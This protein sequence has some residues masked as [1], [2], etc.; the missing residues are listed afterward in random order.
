MVEVLDAAKVVVEVVG[1]VVV[2]EVE[3]IH[4][5]L[6]RLAIG[7]LEGLAAPPGTALPLVLEPNLVLDLLVVGL[8][9]L[10]LVSADEELRG[11]VVLVQLVHTFHGGFVTLEGASTIVA[12]LLRRKP[13]I[14]LQ[15]LNRLDGIL[16]PTEH[17][18]TQYILIATE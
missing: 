3:L 1:G 11:V 8:S 16:G 14:D 18:R 2:A 17:S 7:P 10:R 4:V 5:V 15:R 6:D 12:S 13:V 9:G